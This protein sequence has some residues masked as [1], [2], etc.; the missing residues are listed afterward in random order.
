MRDS[1][2]DPPEMASVNQHTLDEA[3]KKHAM[4]LR[5]E[6]GGGRCVFQYRNLS[7]L[8]FRHADFSQ[9]DFAGCLMMNANL[10]GGKF[11]S[12]NFFGCDLRNSD[13]S[14]AS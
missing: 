6:T 12:T 7:H 8:D 9:A 10:T 14:N 13:F 3:I 2:P 11:A 1:I 4:F 5:G